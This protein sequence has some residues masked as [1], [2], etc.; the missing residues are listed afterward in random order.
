LHKSL[1][2]K[3]ES[4][5]LKELDVIVTQL[6]TLSM[7][8]SLEAFVKG[9]WHIIEPGKELHWNWHNT[10]VCEFLEAFS[11]REFK[12][13]IINIPPRTTKSLIVSVCYPVWVWLQEESKTVGPAHEFL[14][15][16]NENDL[17]LRDASKSKDLIQHE[18]FQ[19][20]WGHR[21]VIPRGKEKLQEYKTTK[22]GHRNSKSLT[23]KLTGRGGDTILID[24]PHDA[25]KALSEQAR[26]TDL[27]AYAGKVTSRLN[28]QTNGGMLIIMQRLHELDLTGY[29][30]KKDGSYHPVDEEYGWLKLCLPMEFV[31][32][33]KH[34]PP[35]NPAGE[36]GFKDPRTIKGELLDTER[37]PRPVVDKL[38]AGLGTYRASGQFQ[39]QPSPDDGGILKK[40]WWRLWP[41]NRPFPR[42]QFILQSYDTAYTKEDHE[43]N[44]NEASG[45]I[46]Y[47]A[48]T[49]WGVFY[50]EWT[51]RYCILLIE[52]WRDHVEYPELRRE[53]K[54]AY[55]KQEPDAV[56][57][58]QK[59]SGQSLIQDL[60]RAGIPVICTTPTVDKIAR[61]YAVSPML[62]SGLIYYP[63]RLWAEECV[64]D[65]AAF[66]NG[67]SED[68]TDTATQAWQ[69]LRKQFRV[70]HPEDIPEEE[71]VDLTPKPEGDREASY[72]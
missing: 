72:G 36:Y 42:C 2:D 61:A 17:A 22:N 63:D 23:G 31:P 35:V 11:R 45:K 58:E 26:K 44:E 70:S 29:V 15:L 20:R 69:R 52:A 30:V 37:F 9:A 53:A 16:S 62:E 50:D 12:R 3:T 39:Q 65:I 34:K 56:L 43:A 60:K 55:N 6:E 19:E 64:S 59:A 66:P 5:L 57:I 1:E 28:S 33:R 40:S 10:V 41:A 48:R 27:S 46:S 13:G 21:V 18:W 47:S 67:A 24:D 25:E 49:T 68:W 51:S 38:A 7:E 8:E 4:A 54:E 14:C 32:K 71:E